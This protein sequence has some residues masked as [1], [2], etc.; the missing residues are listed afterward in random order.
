MGTQY[1]PEVYSACLSDAIR[2]FADVNYAADTSGYKSLM[3][4]AASVAKG[5]QHYDAPAAWNG[6]TREIKNAWFRA[7]QINQQAAS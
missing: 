6:S 4:Y 1:R 5:N 3:W 2:K 7:T